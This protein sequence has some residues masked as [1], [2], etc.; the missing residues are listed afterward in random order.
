[1]AQEKLPQKE[2]SS[3]EKPGIDKNGVPP[4]SLFRLPRFFTQGAD[5]SA[6]ETIGELEEDANARSDADTNSHMVTA[7]VQPAPAQTQTPIVR[8]ASE[9]LSALRD[10]VERLTEQVTQVNERESALERLQERFSLRTSQACGA[11]LA[12]FIRFY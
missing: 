1:M 6:G 5:S 7:K 4:P 11:P 12:V 10:E 3:S 2:A 8:S 9:E